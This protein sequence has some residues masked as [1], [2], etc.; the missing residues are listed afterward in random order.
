MSHSFRSQILAQ[1]QANEISPEEALTLL[2]KGP[3]NKHVQKFRS[4]DVAIIGMSA[5]LPGAQ[6]VDTFWKNLKEGRDSVCEIPIERWD[7]RLFHEENSQIINKSQSYCKS[8]GFIKGVKEF[9]PQF[10]NISPKDAELMDP[11]E[12]LL[13]QNCWHTLEDAVIQ[14]ESITSFKA[15]EIYV[16]RGYRGGTII[17]EM[18]K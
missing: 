9:D 6:D 1:V 2:K 12:R 17:K 16:D 13:L 8:G 14:A 4:K 3:Q 11:Q 5:V 7:Y 18:Q 10:F 15:N